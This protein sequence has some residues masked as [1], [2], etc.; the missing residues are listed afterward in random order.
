MGHPLFHRFI[1]L[2]LVGSTLIS[3]ADLSSAAAFN[4][5]HRASIL[6]A[7]KVP[8]K[9]G[10]ITQVWTPSKVSD[11]KMP[12]FVLIPDLHANLE[13]QRKIA[14]ILKFLNRKN[15]LNVVFTEASHGP[16]DVTVLRNA[17]P[18]LRSQIEEKYLLQ[19]KLLGSEIAAAESDRP[20][21]LWGVDDKALYL[22]NLAAFARGLKKSPAPH[23]KN[24][25][26]TEYY[27]VALKRDNPM[28]TEAIRHMH[29]LSSTPA[30]PSI[31]ALVV[32]GYHMK[33]ITHYLK[34]HER[35][36]LVISPAITKLGSELAHAER[37]KVLAA[38]TRE[39]TLSSPPGLPVTSF[40]GQPLQPTILGDI[41]LS[42]RPSRFGQLVWPIVRMVVSMLAL[43]S[44]PSFALQTFGGGYTSTVPSVVYWVIALG[45]IV[46][47]NLRWSPEWT[48]SR[49][50]K[51]VGWESFTTTVTR[52][53]P[54]RIARILDFINYLKSLIQDNR[55]VGKVFDA[56]LYRVIGVEVNNATWGSKY[57]FKTF[58][59]LEENV[60]IVGPNPLMLERL[61]MMIE[62]QM[63][64][65]WTAEEWAQ[66]AHRH[67]SQG[68]TWKI[69]SV[70]A[71]LLLAVHDVMFF[72][73][74]F[75]YLLAS[76]F[77]AYGM[78]LEL[79]N[80]VDD[81]ISTHHNF[82]GLPD[83]AGED[84][85]TLT[86]REIYR[87]PENYLVKGIAQRYGM[88]P[89][90]LCRLVLKT[91]FDLRVLQRYA[92]FLGYEDDPPD[93]D[94]DPYRRRWQT[95][96]DGGES[97]IHEYYQAIQNPNVPPILRG[98]VIGVYNR[99][100]KGTGSDY[101][102]HMVGEMD[103]GPV[104]KLELS[105]LT[106]NGR[107][108]LDTPI[109]IERQPWNFLCRQREPAKIEQLFSGYYSL[110]GGHVLLGDTPD[111]AMA[112]FF[113]RQLGLNGRLEVKPSQLKKLSPWGTFETYDE[114][115]DPNKE[116][117][118]VYA[119]TS[120]STDQRDRIEQNI[121]VDMEL[122]RRY[123]NSDDYAMAIQ[124]QQA[125]D[126]GFAP[127]IR[128][129]PDEA[130]MQLPAGV[131]VTPDVMIPYRR[132]SYM[133]EIEE[134]E[135]RAQ[136]ESYAMQ[137]HSWWVSPE[138]AAL[139]IPMLSTIVLPILSLVPTLARWLTEVLHWTDFNWRHKSQSQFIVTVL[140]S[141]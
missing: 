34:T 4:A 50:W 73:W 47:Q 118:I 129:A 125:K 76:Y 67:Q 43:G 11:R 5:T 10:D 69:A 128:G 114:E 2:F 98:N 95:L 85:E 136:S 139:A 79:R 35:S 91:E 21:H 30:A 64:P 88:R 46:Y 28:I 127:G 40:V 93:M 106:V 137:Q 115:G 36:Y 78:N 48:A 123:P 104:E 92:L 131:Q 86:Y 133:R 111:K 82:T 31:A 39:H 83:L 66:F 22:E 84:Q 116:L 121:K 25:A 26:W 61:R 122:Q 124:H 58:I 117:R 6:S 65:G 7:I 119:L 134:A 135:S 1:S 24:P 16:F 59:K 29:L 100:T 97:L 49:N 37:L 96:Y 23:P 107:V 81:L 141:V 63:V 9:L 27:A 75:V 32:G 80:K 54:R 19:N 17:A 103:R 89:A 3:G 102:P 94:L 110:Y 8:N 33:G 20:I 74:L 77:I 109:E 68:R 112:Q 140:Q 99:V 15:G 126:P 44:L 108:D 101:F 90:D 130:F 38:M 138:L 62:R 60:H 14:E 52:S 42:A 57:L 120:L 12:L 18:D 113:S 13:A 132:K 71:L 105:H 70:V 72:A 56:M 87:N 51:K 45:L 53:T 41:G 55:L